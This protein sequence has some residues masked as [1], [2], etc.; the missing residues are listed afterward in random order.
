[1]IDGELEQN[2]YTQ[3]VDNIFTIL[4]LDRYLDREKRLI[5]GNIHNMVLTPNILGVNISSIL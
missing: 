4:S 3:M 5:N 2:I 1:M